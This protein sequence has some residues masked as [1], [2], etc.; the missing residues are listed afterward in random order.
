[1]KLY[2]EVLMVLTNAD[3]LGEIQICMYTCL[4]FVVRAQIENH[5]N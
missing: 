1:M 5:A 3:R 4:F 2:T